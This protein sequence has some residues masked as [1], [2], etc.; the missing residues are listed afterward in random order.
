MC[1]RDSS[2]AV[3]IFQDLNNVT[4]ESDNETVINVDMKSRSSVV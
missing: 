2:E 4:V 3:N 1:I